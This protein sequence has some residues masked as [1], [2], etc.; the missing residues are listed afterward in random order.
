MS[1]ELFLSRILTPLFWLHLHGSF[2]SPFLCYH[3]D[4]TAI[5]NGP[6]L[7]Q[8][9]VNLE[10]GWHRLYQT[11]GQLLEC[12]H[13]IH[14][15]SLPTTQ[16]LPQKSDTCTYRSSPILEFPEQVTVSFPTA[17]S[18]LTFLLLSQTETL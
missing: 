12:S 17:E 16:A 18:L 2:F 8:C 9:W 1:A 10:D 5:T 7:G 11:W 15:C 13:R 6:S 3:R 14:P 4:T